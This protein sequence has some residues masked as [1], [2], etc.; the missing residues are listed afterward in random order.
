MWPANQLESIEVDRLPVVS[1]NLE[2][3]SLLVLSGEHHDRPTVL[4]EINDSAPQ[5]PSNPR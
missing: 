3:H 5:Q 1:V 2:F 4:D